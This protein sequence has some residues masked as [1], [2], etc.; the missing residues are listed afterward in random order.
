MN[1]VFLST[2]EH[3]L[4]TIL[5]VKTVD[6]AD[7]VLE[8]LK[9]DHGDGE[10][11]DGMLGTL[12]HAFSPDDGRLH[13]DASELWT[14]VKDDAA[15]EELFN[16]R[17]AV[18]LESVAVHEIGHLLGLGHSSVVN[19][20]MYPSIRTQMRRVYLEADDI[21]GI[22]SLY[23]VNLDYNGTYSG[24]MVQDDHVGDSSSASKVVDSVIWKNLL[25][26]VVLPLMFYLT[27]FKK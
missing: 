6:E 22:Q 18:D 12:A 24:T 9:L 21:D 2:N 16:S 1:I 25:I 11:F 10:P 15:S 3:K 20:V 5:Q 23:G 13:F 27:L 19:S 26:V 7:I 17:A 8:F 4:S 14:A